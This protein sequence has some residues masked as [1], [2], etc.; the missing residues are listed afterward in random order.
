MGSL[1]AVLQPSKITWASACVS[2]CVMLSAIR[3]TPS[4]SAI[5]AASPAGSQRLHDLLFR[6][7]PS[8]ISFKF[9][10]ESLAVFLFV[11]CV[12]AAQKG[13]P[14]PHDGRLNALHFGNI[15]A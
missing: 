3:F 6:C 13:R 9:V 1:P 2:V 14:A 11:G 5:L 4:R 12:D 15:H 8:R 10:L 7:E